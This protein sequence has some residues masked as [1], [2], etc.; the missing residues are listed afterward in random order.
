MTKERKC[1]RLCQQNK[2]N[3]CKNQEEKDE[4]LLKRRSEHIENAIQKIKDSKQGRA[5][6][7]FKMR[8]DIV[9]PKKCPQEASSIRDPNTG[10]IL[11]NKNRIKE[12]TL[13]YCIKNLKQNIPDDEFKEVVKNRKER[14]IKIMNDKEGETFEVTFEEYEK[15][16]T[17]FARKDTKTYDFILKSGDEYKKAIYKLCKRIIEKEEVPASFHKTVLIMLWKRKGS[18]EILKNNRFLHMKEVLARC[19]DAIIVNQMKEPLTSKLSIYQVGGLPGHSILEHLLTLKTVLARMEEIDG[20]II[21]LVMDIVSFFDKEDIFDC[22]NTLEILEV[23]KKAVRMWYLMN[24]DTK[25]SIKT[26]FGMTKEAVIGDCLGQGTAGAGLVSAANLD[27]GLQKYFKQS[28]EVMNYGQIR[29]QPLCY[30]DDVS[31]PCFNIEMAKKQAKMMTRMLKEKTLTAH[32]DK[33]GILLLGS[34]TYKEKMKRELKD[35]EI[36]LD[37]FHLKVKPQDKYLGQIFASDLSTSALA[38]V[39]EREGRIKGAAIEVKAI[40]EDYQMQAMGGLVA[41]WELWER[42][43]V[44][45]LLSGAGTWLGNIGEATTLCNKIQ[46][47][48]WRTILKISSS[49]PKLALLCEPKMTDF[50]WRIYEEKCMLLLQIKCLEEG[51]LA[52]IIYEEAELNSWPGLGKDVRQI[53]LDIGIPDLNCNIMTKQDIKKAIQH[54]HY[55]HM[56]QLFEGSSKLHDIKED[57]FR[58]MQLYFNDKNLESARTKFKIRTKMLEKI[59]GNFKNLYKNQENGLKCDLCPDEMTQNHCLICPER[60]ELRKNLDMK[61]LDDLVSYFG[62]LLSDR[63][64]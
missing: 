49:C 62:Q 61:N 9:G 19:V 43:L 44:P 59:P 38:T 8:K 28:R 51:S 14:Q 21:L 3:E 5:G 55:E 23:N 35:S 60:L 34:K 45:S 53:C 29:I 39:K 17:K 33:S 57:D 41:A 31:S 63:S 64:T 54:S 52:K 25:I 56:M 40:I 16:L 13:Q 32:P 24:K 22:L 30:Q 4:E 6:N 37:N 27:M 58:S 12:A 2:C 46:N 7:I 15:V 20:G 18:M 10:E 48:Y 47:F 26:A 42:A 50:K 36:Y 11:V 1:T